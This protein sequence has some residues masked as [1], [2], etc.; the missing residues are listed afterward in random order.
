MCVWTRAVAAEYANCTAQAAAAWFLDLAKAYEHL[1]HDCLRLKAEETGFSLLLLEFLLGLYGMRRSIVVDG[2]STGFVRARR[3]VVPGC[4]FADVLMRLYMLTP[5]DALAQ[6][7]PSLMLAVV[8]DDV[9]GMVVGRR[10]AVANTSARAYR[11]AR[12]ALEAIGLTLSDKKLVFMTNDNEVANI[13]ARLCPQ[14]ARAGTATARNLGI[15]FAIGKRRLIAA[16]RAN[17]LKMVRKRALKTRKLKRAGASVRKLVSQSLNPAGTYGVGNTGATL[18][19][20]ARMRTAAHIAMVKRPGGRSATI[21]LQ[22]AGPQPRNIDPGIRMLSEPIPVLANALWENWLPRHMILRVAATARG[23]ALANEGSW[24]GVVHPVAAALTSAVRLGWQLGEDLVSFVSRDGHNLHILRQ[25]PNT[26]RAVAQ[27]DAQRYLLEKATARAP[28]LASITHVPYIEPLR[29]LANGRNSLE[30]TPKHQGMLRAITANA[31]WPQQRLFQT[32]A[33]DDP[34]CK[35]CGAVGTTWHRH[36]ECPA[37]AP[38]RESYGLGTL[39]QQEGTYKFPALW[40][41]G[42]IVDP[43]VWLPLPAIAFEWKWIVQPV[44][45]RL[46]GPAWGDGS[47]KHQDQIRQARSGWGVAQVVPNAAAFT[48]FASVCGPLPGPIQTTPAAE[49]YALLAY[50]RLVGLPP[51]DYAADNQWVVDSWLGGRAHCTGGTHVHADIWRAIFD[52]TDDLGGVDNIVVRKVKGHATQRGI[53]NGKSTKID[54]AGNNA[55]DEAAKAGRRMHPYDETAWKRVAR[56]TELVNF[57]A[58]FQARLAVRLA[59]RGWPDTT[60]RGQWRGATRERQQLR[61]QREANSGGH[62]LHQQQDGRWR[63]MVCLRSAASTGGLRQHQCTPG[64]RHR[65]FD[66]GALVFCS[67]CGA[68]SRTRARGLLGECRGAKSTPAA[69]AMQLVWQGICPSTGLLLAERPVP[70][71]VSWVDADLPL[72]EAAVSL[73]DDSDGHD[74]GNDAG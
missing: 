39:A 18:D 68:Y 74:S 47:T 16:V 52:K 56:M 6:A 28:H 63:C 72:A 71:G 69:K 13:V 49:A 1:R 5:M 37:S 58:K 59:E 11:Q 43:T 48:T 12:A 70:V 7:W 35:A 21:D 22:L 33:V 51:Y 46:D 45:N 36:L 66:A 57:V 64:T 8:V 60:A 24:R 15:D 4:S 25:C 3:S 40:T 34:D 30:W 32:G 23:K 19:E 65:I 10:A 54:R 67:C 20:V 26:V 38:F 17:R 73:L 2:V 53:T 42:L 44:S 50:L 14:L 41:H 27:L 9:Q 31:M 62:H 61:R 55:A 29:A